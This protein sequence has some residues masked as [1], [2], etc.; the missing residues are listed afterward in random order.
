M[1]EILTQLG[2]IS[3]N[4]S[5]IA[6]ALNEIAL[7]LAT[8]DTATKAV[9]EAVD[10]SQPAKTESCTTKDE[11]PAKRKRNCVNGRHRWKAHEIAFIVDLHAKRVEPDSIAKALFSNYGVKVSVDAIRRQ[12]KLHSLL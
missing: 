2:V 11:T 3:D 12:C 9:S 8:L 10:A 7:S 4:L 6:A 1:E 5:S